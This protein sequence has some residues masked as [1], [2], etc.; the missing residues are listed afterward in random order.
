MTFLILYDI[1]N[2]NYSNNFITGIKGDSDKFIPLW[3]KKGDIE[4]YSIIL[5]DFMPK[6]I[7]TVKLNTNYKTIYEENNLIPIKSNENLNLNIY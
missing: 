7:K 5:T 3:K 4:D 2:I 1:L 6:S